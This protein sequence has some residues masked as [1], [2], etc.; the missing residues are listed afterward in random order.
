MNNKKVKKLRK[1]FNSALK[2]KNIDSSEPLYNINQQ[3]VRP[4]LWRKFKNNPESIKLI[5]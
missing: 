3:V 1:L 2:L 4:N 5:Q